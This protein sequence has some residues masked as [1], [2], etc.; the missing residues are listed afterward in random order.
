MVLP[1]GKKAIPFGR[2]SVSVSKVIL[3]FAEIC[4][5]PDIWLSFRDRLRFF[6]SPYGGS[7]K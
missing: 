6:R 4:K 5:H 2:V 3:P 7:V 1:P